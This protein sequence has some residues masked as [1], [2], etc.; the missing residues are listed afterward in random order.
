M[1]NNAVIS[2]PQ[3]Y[4]LGSS[5]SYALLSADRNTS[6]DALKAEFQD[7]IV[8]EIDFA[9]RMNLKNVTNVKKCRTA[10][11]TVVDSNLALIGNA[12]VEEDTYEP[13]V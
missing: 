4:R 11:Q 13:W 5:S 10:I 1:A 6:Q 7:Q 3:T 12:K 8:F 9:T 2:S